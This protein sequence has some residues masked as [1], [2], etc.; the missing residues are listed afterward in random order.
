MKNKPNGQKAAPCGPLEL[1]SMLLPEPQSPGS[2]QPAVYDLKYFFVLCIVT[3]AMS[4]CSACLAPH[5]LFKDDL[6]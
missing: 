5:V 1:S 4:V 3:T 2:L 6:P